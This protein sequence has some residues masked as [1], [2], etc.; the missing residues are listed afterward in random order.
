DIYDRQYKSLSQL[1]V[2]P[3][4][5]PDLRRQMDAQIAEAKGKM[6]QYASD[7]AVLGRHSKELGLKAPCDGIVMTP[8]HVAEIGKY[9]E[10]GTPFCS[11][12]DPQELAVLLPVSPADYRLLKGDYYKTK[13]QGKVLPVT[14][15]V[16]GRADL[17][18]Q[19]R[20]AQ[21]PESEAKEIPV[22][23]TN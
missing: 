1:V 6:D 15:R 21:M 8:A 20:I 17:T 14:L 9:Y 3:N 23:L 11:V 2:Q 16:Q 4:I 12:G 22:Q 7:I 13:D 18:W 10:K 19:G 5:H